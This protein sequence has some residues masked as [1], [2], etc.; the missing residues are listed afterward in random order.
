MILFTTADPGFHESVESQDK[1]Y[2]NRGKINDTMR[3]RLRK[4]LKGNA[5]TDRESRYEIIYA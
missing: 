3:R 2:G 4:P 1:Q 5:T